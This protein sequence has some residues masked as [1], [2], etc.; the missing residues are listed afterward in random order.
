MRRSA[1]EPALDPIV[2]VFLDSLWRRGT[3]C[4]L[5]LP[6]A[7]MHSKCRFGSAVRASQR[8][9]ISATVGAVI[10]ERP[11]SGKYPESAPVREGSVYTAEH[12]VADDSL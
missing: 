8:L 6:P 4:C 9:T 11:R 10:E 12:Y 3:G 5:V 2:L 7:G 1:P